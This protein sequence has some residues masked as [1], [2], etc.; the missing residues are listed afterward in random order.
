[1]RAGIIYKY[2]S[3]SGKIYIGQ[4]TNE[5]LRKSQHKSQAKN[6]PK[7]YFHRAIRK[8][9]FEN[10]QYEVIFRTASKDESRLKFL[11]NTMETYFIKKYDSNNPDKGYNLT[12][13]GEGLFNPSDEVRAR[14]GWTKGVNRTD[15]VKAKISDTLKQKYK[16]GEI[17]VH[18]KR[19]IQV[20]KNKELVAEYDSVEAARIALNIAYTSITNILKGR[21]K[22]TRQGYTFTY[23]QEGGT[24]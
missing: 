10:F 11:L 23:K 9:G 24:L 12:T 6:N 21:A 14:I 18:N 13:G 3:P 4:T 20:F 19:A 17:S 7:D 16:T 8:Y 15:E 5:A 1:M 22:R 2:S